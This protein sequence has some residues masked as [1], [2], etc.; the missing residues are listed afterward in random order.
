MQAFIDTIGERVGVYS[1]LIELGYKNAIS[2]KFSESVQ[3][4]RDIT[5]VYEFANM[6]TYLL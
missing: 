3:G 2:Y 4:L 1:R 6:R 5:G